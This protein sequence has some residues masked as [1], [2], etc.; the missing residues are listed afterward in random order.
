MLPE[1]AGL[2]KKYSEHKNDSNADMK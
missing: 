2:N 1:I